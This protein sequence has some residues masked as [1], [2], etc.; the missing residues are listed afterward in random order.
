MIEA[1][2]RKRYPPSPDS[3]GFLLDLELAAA[4]GV[5]VLFGPSGSGKTLT[6]ECIAGFL[7]PDEGRILL[8]GRLLF[9][10]AS[11][12]HLPPRRRQC[13]YVF[14]NYALFPHMSLR[15]NLQFAAERLPRLERHRKTAEMIDRF[16]LA[17]VA[18]RMPHELS[19]GQRQRASIAR[20]LLAAPRMLLLDE[21]AQGLDAPLRQE[22]YSVLRE[23]RAEFSLPILLVTHDLDEACALGGQMHVLREGA[24]VQ[25]GPPASLVESPASLDVLRLLGVHS[26]LEAEIRSLDPAR[27]SS[28]LRVGDQN[29]AGPYFPGR[30]K[31][32]RVWVYILPERIAARPRL[33]AALQPH[34]IPVTLAASEGRAGRVLLEFDG[35]WKAFLSRRE[36]AA[37]SAE[38][39]WILEFEPEDLKAL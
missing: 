30:F 39:E 8:D 31:G 13:G 2:L 7:Q 4:P 34:Q 21:P 24:I 28:L 36:F 12:I 19:G 33:G 27:R 17:E 25:S 9:D 32:D 22:L 37:C 26:A 38:R 6:L 14:Q 10:A 5:T 35:G 20:A 16:R 23:V 15:A 11:G 29:V 18:S 1:R 3:P